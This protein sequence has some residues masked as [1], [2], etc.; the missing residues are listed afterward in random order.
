MEYFFLILIFI[1]LL[2][3]YS[4]INRK[5]RKLNETIDKQN[6]L[7]VKLYKKVDQVQ[8]R[9]EEGV[10]K[11][12]I[13]AKERVIVTPIPESKLKPEEASK[14]YNE[15]VYKRPEEATQTS[16]ESVEQIE[17]LPKFEEKIAT[18]QVPKIDLKSTK[19]AENLSPISSQD[20]PKPK[21]PSFMER[22]PDLE[23]FIGEN[24]INK[25]GIAILVLGIGYFV[26]YAIDK[27]W[28]NEI[29]RVFIGVLAGGILMGTAHRLRKNFKAFSSVLIGGGLTVFYFTIGIA[30]HEYQLIPQMAAFGIMV[31]ITAFAVLLSIAYDRQELAVL[32]IIG[33]F[34]TPFI[35]STGEGNFVVL[36][37]YL[38]ILDI[39]MLV[40]ASVK[41]WSLVNL[42][43][44]VFTVLIYAGWLFTKYVDMEVQPVGTAFVFGAAFYMVFHLMQMNYNLIK[45]HPFTAKELMVMVSNTALFYSAGMFLLEGVESIKLTGLFTAGM[46]AFNFG[47]AFYAYTKKKVDKKLFFLLIGIVLTFLSLTAPVQLEGNHITLFWAAET[48]LL[49]W[50]SDKSGILLI[51]RTVPVIFVAMIISLVIDYYQIYIEESSL[52]PLLNRGFITSMVAVGFTGVQLFLLNRKQSILDVLPGIPEHIYTKFVAVV[53]VLLLYFGLLSELSFQVEVHYGFPLTSI[54]VNIYNFA[55]VL[56][57]SVVLERLKTLGYKPVQTV[58]SWLAM[59]IYLVPYQYAVSVYCFDAIENPESGAGAFWINYIGLTLILL[60]VVRMVRTILRSDLK[61]KRNVIALWG[62]SIW[63]VLLACLELQ[64]VMLLIGYSTEDSL[65][66]LNGHIVKTGYTIVLGLFSFL[67]MIYGMMKKVK[68]IRIISLT[69]FAFTLLKL[70][71]YDIRDIS[72]G[73][74]IAAFIF[75]GVLL[76]TISFMYQKLK[77]LILDEAPESSNEQKE[78]GE[79][80]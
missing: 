33:G 31:V 58:L 15:E 32:S 7:L 45:N 65:D 64:H 52:T 10:D 75:L 77:V 55:F 12:K 50:L 27:D 51:R 59:L 18:P 36:F 61:E 79:H 21:K 69:F 62:V 74:K 26:K 78:G 28:I 25:I 4:G 66:V 42:L 73:G 46:G 44:F 35:L 40:L 5:F 19:P 71:L 56:V 57:L 20:A 60:I 30:F 17:E 11:E 1:V 41:K 70:F 76:L 34:S 24:L 80:A 23:K 13:S 22:N 16:K 38:L 9:N 47:F 14:E 43:P 2:M 8:T 72:E 67:F 3:A 29:G 49:L 54:W 68:T 6:K 37:T 48:V 63:I 53:G 39:G